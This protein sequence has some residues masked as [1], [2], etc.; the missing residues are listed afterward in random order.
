MTDP[1]LVVGLGNPGPSYAGNRHNVGQMVL[2]ELGRRAGVAFGSH[3][4]RAQVADVR[5]GVLPGGVPGPRVLLAK[6][7]SYMNVSGGPV[8]SLS[9][10]LGVPVERLV[11]VHDE[12][13][14][15]FAQ[16]KLKRGG[17]E[18]GHNGLRSI[19]SAVGSKDYVRVRVGVGRP[20]GRMD[21]ADFVLK[22][23]STVERKDLPWLVDAAADAVEMVVLE[24]LEAA[25]QRFHSPS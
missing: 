19:T 5:L 17:G 11:V 20:P 15:P 12:L 10:Y 13:D 2:D 9:S 4:S 6:P 24:G 1:W 23:F 14:I 21:P 16:V 8:A 7:T 3:R 25:Q 18:G 22:D